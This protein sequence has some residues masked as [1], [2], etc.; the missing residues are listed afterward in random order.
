MAFLFLLNIAIYCQ[1]CYIYIVI[2]FKY[3]MKILVTGGAGYIGSTA[4]HMLIE[5]GHDVLIFDNL[6]NGNERLI[7]PDA[8]FIKGDLLNPTD[9]QNTFKDKGIDAVMHFAAFAEVGESVIH[10]QKYYFN[11]V[12][13]SLNLFEA[14]INNNVLKLIFSS[15]CA[16]FGQPEKLPITEMTPQLPTNPYGASKLMIERILDDYDKAYNFKSICLRYFNAAGSLTRAKIG[17]MHNPESHLIPNILKAA[18]GTK[19]YIQINGKDYATKDGTCVRDYVHVEDLIEAH[20]L[21]L[22]YLQNKNKSEKFNLGSEKG[23]SI[24]EVINTAKEISRSDFSVKE[25]PRRPGDPAILIAGS[26]KIR[27]K[28]GWQAKKSLDDII[29]DAWTW[30]QEVNKAAL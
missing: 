8:T 22:N 21:A 4:V 15:T 18:I 10:P 30:E 14:M 13:G 5:K 11:N 16:T 3:L 9:L 7:H 29:N 23:F 6:S 25:G 12:V 2:F 26:D 20:I 19:E 17:E 28:L 24:L 27:K 1:I